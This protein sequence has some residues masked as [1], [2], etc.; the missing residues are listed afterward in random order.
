M[1]RRVRVA[2]LAVGL[3][4]LGGC[5][6]QTAPRRPSPAAVAL[7][8]ANVA[9]LTAALRQGGL[10]LF[11]VHAVAESGNEA[12]VVLD[13]CATQRNLTPGGR[14][15]AV[16]I[17]TAVRRQRIPIGAVRSSP[18]CR[19]AD[20]ARI[21]FG[22]LLLDDD[23]LPARG[24]GAAARAAAVRRLLGTPPLPGRNTVLVGHADTSEKLFGVALLPGEALLV[25]PAAG[26]G[27]FAPLGRLRAEQW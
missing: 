27:G 19:C 18:F 23:L 14:D 15:Q 13:D 3:T 9:E 4:V 1:R 21:A 16:A 8:P 22:H 12:G 25:R 11:L 26:G 7:P 6:S 17:A 24:S 10:V 2:M 5:P 20:T